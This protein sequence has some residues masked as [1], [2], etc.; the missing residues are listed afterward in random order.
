MLPVMDD[1][2]RILDDWSYL[3]A[4]LNGFSR[5]LI[6]ES[7]VRMTDHIPGNIIEFGVAHGGSTRV[8]RRTLTKLDRFKLPARRKRIFAC[9]SFKGLPEK[10]ENAEVGTFACKPPRIR[11]VEIVEGYFQD[12]LTEELARRVGKV[13]VA[14][15]DADLYSST[16]CALRWLTP[17]LQTGSVLLFDEFLGENESE[18]R[19]FEEWSEE[20]KVPTVLIAEFL[21]D[22][23]GWGTKIDR[24]TVYQ[25][26]HPDEVPRRPTAW[27]AQASRYV[28]PLRAVARRVKHALK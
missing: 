13:S 14:S 21:R 19:A 4:R 15:L 11:G 12:S 16:L 7:L 20:T 8:I 3:G 23:S 10:F 2:K 6:L 17:L 25:V 9:D 24:R 26:V 22:P 27:T 1:Q 28:R 18:K 5:E